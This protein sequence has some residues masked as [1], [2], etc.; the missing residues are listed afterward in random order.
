MGP[1]ICVTFAADG[2]PKRF[3]IVRKTL[4]LSKR[5]H[6]MLERTYLQKMTDWHSEKRKVVVRM[7]SR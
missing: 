7:V 5:T 2:R 6:S 4:H 1:E 3:H